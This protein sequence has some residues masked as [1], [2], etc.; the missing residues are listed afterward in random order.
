MVN[1]ILYTFLKE[2]EIECKLKKEK[3]WC[4]VCTK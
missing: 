1:L 2:I 4:I 3:E